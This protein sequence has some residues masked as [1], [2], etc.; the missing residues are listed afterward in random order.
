MNTHHVFLLPIVA[1]IAMLPGAALAQTPTPKQRPGTAT[2][3]AQVKPLPQ[4]TA[5]GQK[6]STATAAKPAPKTNPPET[7]PAKVTPTKQ[8]TLLGQ[9][10]GWGAYW[11]APDGRKV[12]F[13]AARPNSTQ[14]N[15][16]R[17][18]AYLFITSRPYDKVKDE[19]SA[20]VS[21]PLKGNADATA[22]IGKKQYAL[23][24]QSDGVWIK[25]QTDETKLV[26]DMRKGGDLV[27]KATTD[28]GL[29][30][31]DTFSM[32]GLAQALDRI[33]RECK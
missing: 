21:F 26:D 27:L 28:R 14:T 22:V 20:I 12:C 15:R 24:A 33:S 4:Q 31:T 8:P 1:A 16:G 18:P 11:A 19:V 23:S 5:P 9:Y 25:N 30:S 13:A 17:T 7:T 3:P 29:Q 2:A 32:K 10:D 6:P